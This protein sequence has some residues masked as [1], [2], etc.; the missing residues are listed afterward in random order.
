MELERNPAWV[1]P[2]AGKAIYTCPMHPQIEQDRPGDCPICGMALEPMVARAEAPDERELRGM[3]RRFW[4]G[5]SLSLPTLV[6]RD[7]LDVDVD[8]RASRRLVLG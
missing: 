5:L 3:T 8:R 6:D 4:I 2:A 1:A 7:L